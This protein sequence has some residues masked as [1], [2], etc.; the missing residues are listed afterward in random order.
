M[1]CSEPVRSGAFAPVASAF[2]ASWPIAGAAG[3]DT[4]KRTVVVS[5]SAESDTG[6]DAGSTRQPAGTFRPMFAVAAPLVLF[7]TVTRTSLR[8]STPA[9]TFSGTIITDGSTCSARPGT[10]FS[11]M[12]FSP[13]ARSPA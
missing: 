7:S 11:S 4:M 1:N 3:G 2:S 5:P 10:T 9:A 12:R 6:C 8:R 13:V